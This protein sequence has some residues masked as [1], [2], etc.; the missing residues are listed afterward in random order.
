[1]DTYDDLLQLD[2]SAIISGESAPP[3]N[4]KLFLVCTNGKRDR[5]CAKHGLP[6]YNTMSTIAGESVWQTTHIAGHRFAA[7]MLCFPHGLCYGRLRADDAKAVVESYHSGQILLDKFR[8]RSCYSPLAQAAEYYLRDHANRYGID[9]LRLQDE[10]S[11]TVDFKLDNQV[12]RV[13]LEARLSEWSSYQSCNAPAPEHV[14]QY[15]L[16]SIER[17]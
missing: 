4:E 12:Y 9:D 7:T 11:D 17:M 2:L 1:L 5:C 10:R 15:F 8:G 14:T 16:K 3:T 6:L 13:Q